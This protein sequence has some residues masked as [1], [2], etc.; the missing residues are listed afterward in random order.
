[1]LEVEVAGLAATRATDA[2]IAKMRE[3][4]KRMEAEEDVDAAS[5]HDVEFH[6]AIARAT[7]NDLHLLLLDSIGDALIEIRR[8]NL[9]GGSTADTL[10]SHREILDRIAARDPEGARRAMR[11]HLENVEE[12]WRRRAARGSAAEP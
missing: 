12:H 2:D 1:M 7:Q 4:C 9:A 5:L 6:R 10:A 11:A 8:E 3:I